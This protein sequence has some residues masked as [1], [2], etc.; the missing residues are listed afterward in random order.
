MQIY[1]NFLNVTNIKGDFYVILA[2]NII[3]FTI[4]LTI[5]IIIFLLCTFCNT[6]HLTSG[7]CQR[8]GLN[9]S[10]LIKQIH[11]AMFLLYL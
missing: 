4:K 11:P 3:E 7:Q 10:F 8:Q 5:C 2:K 9:T 6:P 1:D